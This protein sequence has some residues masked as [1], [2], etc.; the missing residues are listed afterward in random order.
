MAHRSQQKTQRHSLGVLAQKGKKRKSLKLID[1]G[2]QKKLEVEAI[3][4]E[5]WNKEL[6]VSTVKEERK[7]GEGRR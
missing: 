7:E 5:R 6:L 2:S 4:S 3:Q 1:D